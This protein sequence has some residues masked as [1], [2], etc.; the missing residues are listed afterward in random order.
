M[1]FKDQADFE[2]RLR[3]FLLEHRPLSVRVRHTGPEFWKE[4]L[5]WPDEIQGDGPGQRWEL[6][7][8][9][10]YMKNSWAEYAICTTSVSTKQL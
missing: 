10:Q 2:F 3:N 4:E 5:Q 7:D 1:T 6:I 9:R 8:C